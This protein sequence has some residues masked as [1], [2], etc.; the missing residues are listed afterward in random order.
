LGTK[1][2]YKFVNDNPLVEF[3]PTEIINDPFNVAQNKK[4]VAI[5]SALQVDLTGQV[6]ADSIGSRLHS[7][8]GGQWDFIYGASRS[9]GG[10]PIIVLPSTVTLKNKDKTV[11]SRIVPQLEPGAGVTISRYHIHYVVTEY[12][13][14]YLYGQTLKTRARE[15]ISIAHPKFRE[16]LLKQVYE[17][18]R[19]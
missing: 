18:W 12:G 10:K 3:W 5:N 13:V 7:G 14:A 11:K 15:L 6:C 4:M 17:M 2:L 8:V 16:D 1:E 19:Y 9:E